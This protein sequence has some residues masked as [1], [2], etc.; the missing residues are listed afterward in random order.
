MV[1]CRPVLFVAEDPLLW[2]F[3]TSEEP[4][5]P[6]AVELTTTKPRFST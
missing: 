6:I 1:F 3:L 2:L 4:T 5:Q